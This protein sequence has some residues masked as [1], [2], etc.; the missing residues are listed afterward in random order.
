MKWETGKSGHLYKKATIFKNRF[1]DLHI[2]KILGGGYIRPHVDNGRQLRIN[3]S[4]PTY[5]KGGI[6]LCYESY[7]NL[8]GISVYR[9]DKHIHEFTEVVCGSKY[10][11]S[12]GLYY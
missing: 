10:V 11:V 3:I 4:T 7:L 9:A 5:H 12:F 2:L 6:F 1:F 8:C